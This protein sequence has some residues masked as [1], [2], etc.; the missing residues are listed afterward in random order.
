MTRIN[1]SRVV[2][3]GVVAGLVMGIGE[4]VHILYTASWS[5]ALTDLGAVGPTTVTAT[6][7]SVTI[8]AA[9]MIMMWVYALLREHYGAGPATAVRV[10]VAFAFFTHLLPAVALWHFGLL[11]AGVVA[12]HAV[13]GFVAVPI[14]VVAGAALYQEKEAVAMASAL[15]RS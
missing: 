1:V 7:V 15:G 3:G 6:V 2:L 8:L 12:L 5:R 10:G 4:A 9:G 13:W 11:P 14:G